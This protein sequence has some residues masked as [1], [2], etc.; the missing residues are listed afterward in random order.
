LP[1]YEKYGMGR[2]AV[3][4]KD[5]RGFIGWGG[6]KYIEESAIYDLGYRFLR[7]QWGNGYATESAKAAMAFGHGVCYLKRIMG[8]ADV[9]NAGSVKVLEKVGVKFERLDHVHGGNIATYTSIK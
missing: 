9:L 8:Q 6:I 4:R 5:T 3:I 2:L 1:Q 7:N